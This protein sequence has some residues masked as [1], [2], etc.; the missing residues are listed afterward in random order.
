MEAGIDGRVDELRFGGSGLIPINILMGVCKSICKII[1]ANIRGSGFLIK[2]QKMNNPF[3]CL[4][5]CEHVISK[6][7]INAKRTIEVLYDN[8]TK[9]INLVLDKGER[10]IRDYKYLNIDATVIEI[11]DKDNIE[12]NF[13]LEPDLRYLND[14]GKYL[15]KMI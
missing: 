13:F 7:I 2:L 15:N 6:D 11:L 9:K 4:I 12:K 1:I 8:Q 3:Y 10:F 5:T 14:Y